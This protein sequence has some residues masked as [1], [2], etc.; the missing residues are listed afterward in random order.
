MI[1]LTCSLSLIANGTGRVRTS[2]LWLLLCL[3]GVWPPISVAQEKPDKVAKE[4]L[5][6]NKKKR[7]YY[8]FVPAGI[9]A[10]APLIVLLHGSGRDGFSLIDK[11]KD[12]ASKEGIIIVGP[13]SSGE[14]WS[15]PRDGPVFLHDLVEELKS[16]Y[17]INPRRVYLFGHSAG[18]VFALMMSTVESEYFAATAIHAGAFRSPNEFQTIDSAS[19]KIPV[20]IWVGTVD[21]FFPLA[22][23]HATRDAFRGKGFTFAS[24][25][26][27]LWAAKVNDS[28]RERGDV[29]HR[30]G[31]AGNI[32]LD[33]IR[34][35]PR[36]IAD[37]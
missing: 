36:G 1:K 23:V 17:P 7:T 2:Y 33:Q 28:L 19:R 30:K 25:V 16:R 15:T 10:P 27:I 22:D 24:K 14:G 20:A 31:P 37:N 13:D 8:L 32:G 26:L 3:F 5:V 35:T 29:T 11:W 12:L 21:P 4:S 6:S 34:G 18:A 9:K